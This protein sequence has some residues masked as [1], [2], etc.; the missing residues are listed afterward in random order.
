MLNG[1]NGIIYVS[2]VSK[3][4]FSLAERCP[5]FLKHGIGNP[6]F[7][8]A[9]RLIDRIPYGDWE[10]QNFFKRVAEANRP[11]KYTYELIVIR[12]THFVNYFVN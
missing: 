2:T 6:A 1:Y 10:I 11:L 3:A 8:F 9:R 7:M 4:M 12:L 5:A